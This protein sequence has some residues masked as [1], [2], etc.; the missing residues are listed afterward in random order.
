[1]AKAKLRDEQDPIGFFNF[2]DAYLE[3]ARALRVADIP[4]R[5]PHRQHPVD[6]LYYQAIELFLKAFLRL[7]NVTTAQ[8]ASKRLGHKLGEL[9]KQASRLG[10]RV[11]GLDRA[12]LKFIDD[13]E[14][15]ESSRYIRTGTAHSIS[16]NRLD[17][18]CRRLRQPIGEALRDGGLSVRHLYP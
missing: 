16:H 13:Y 8:L 6:F 1:M 4:R 9:A 10:L 18:I 17:Q 5:V 7:R 12:L 14:A 15:I 3:S 2:A 11:K